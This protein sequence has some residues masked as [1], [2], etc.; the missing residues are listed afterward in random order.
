MKAL[1]DV[2]GDTL[3]ALGWTNPNVIVLD[4]DSFRW[5]SRSKTLSVSQSA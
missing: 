1:R 4:A 3:V 2:F 5:E